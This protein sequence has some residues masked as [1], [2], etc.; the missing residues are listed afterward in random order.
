MRHKLLRS[1]RASLSATTEETPLPRPKQKGLHLQAGV[2]GNHPPDLTRRW[3]A[4][5]AG[6]GCLCD[7]RLA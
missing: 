5:T 7:P 1:R 4:P 3:V 6:R 2:A